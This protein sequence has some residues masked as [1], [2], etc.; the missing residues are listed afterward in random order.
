MTGQNRDVAEFYAML[1]REYLLAL[2]ILMGDSIRLAQPC[3]VGRNENSDPILFDPLDPCSFGRSFLS[4]AGPETVWHARADVRD[5]KDLKELH[6]FHCGAIISPRVKSLIE[7]FGVPNIEFIPLRVLYRDTEEVIANWFF[8]NVFNWRDVFDFGNS[9]VDCTDF[10][11]PISGLRKI[12]SSFGERAI[13]DFRRLEVDKR[14]LR[15]GLYLARAPMEKIWN[16]VFISPHLADKINGLFKEGKGID[17][18]KFWLDGGPGKKFDTS[19][20]IYAGS[21]D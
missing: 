19:G 8:M 14:Q 1:R 5:F 4:G 16:N 21:G 3:M 6:G 2:P 18:R 15:D 7:D 11:Q 10:F 17:F 13:A 9:D 20:Y 12:S